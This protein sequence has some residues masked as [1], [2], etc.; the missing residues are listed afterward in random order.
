MCVGVPMK[1][2]EVDYPA[3]VAEA[4]G[5]RREIG[6]QLMP[7]GSLEIGDFVIVHVGFAIEKVDKKLAAEIWESL[8]EILRVMDEEENSA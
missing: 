3:G 7:E 1:L 6:L 5:V 8:D 2:V 4:K